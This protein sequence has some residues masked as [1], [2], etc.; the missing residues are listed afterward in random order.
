MQ[1][2]AE[3]AR[4]IFRGGA[5][6]CAIESRATCQSNAISSRL[7]SV[8]MSE[9]ILYG[10]LITRS[11][12]RERKCV[13]KSRAQIDGRVIFFGKLMK[14]GHGDEWKKILIQKIILEIA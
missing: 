5:K 1:V 7:L 2:G 10:D 8:G 9:G 3:K 13:D 4:M 14:P 12:R 6:F 11:A